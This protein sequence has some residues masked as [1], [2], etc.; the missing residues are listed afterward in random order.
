MYS[1]GYDG[2][3][4]SLEA[5]RWNGVRWVAHGTVLDDSMNNFPP[6]RLPSGEW[7]MTRRD[8]QRQV[9]VMIGGRH[10]DY[11]HMIEHDGH[12]L[13]AFSGAKQRMEV[14]KVSLDELEGLAMP[15]SVELASN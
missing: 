4:L 11:P 9:S 7:M 10:V 6:K 3:G 5:F 2:L 14:M 13:V 1:S 15:E 12:L 8:H